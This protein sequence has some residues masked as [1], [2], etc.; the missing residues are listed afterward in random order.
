MKECFN[1]RMTDMMRQAEKNENV[2][3]NKPARTFIIIM[4]INAA[5]S[6]I[7]SYHHIL[8]FYLTDFEIIT[9]ETI[10]TAF[11]FL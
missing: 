2:F 8:S 5:L 6:H 9:G 10:G 1:V 3:S 11:L 7:I 4:V